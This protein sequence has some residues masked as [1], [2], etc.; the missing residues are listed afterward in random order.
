VIPQNAD[1]KVFIQ[2]NNNGTWIPVSAFNP[3]SYDPNI[4]YDYFVETRLPD[5]AGM[6]THASM[7]ISYFDFDVTDSPSVKIVY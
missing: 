6:Y 7:Y 1:Y 2:R 4:R 5:G 3:N